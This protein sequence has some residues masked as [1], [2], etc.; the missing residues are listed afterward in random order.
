MKKS[1]STRDGR[2]VLRRLVLL[3]QRIRDTRGEPTSK[4]LLLD[5]LHAAG[6]EISFRTLDSDLAELRAFAQ[7][8]GSDLVY[9]PRQNAYRYSDHTHSFLAI[10]FTPYHLEALQWMEAIGQTVPT[11]VYTHFQGAVSRALEAFELQRLVNSADQWQSIFQVEAPVEAGREFVVPLAKAC[12]SHEKLE[13]GYKRYFSTEVRIH[14]VLPL[15]LRFWSG[16]WYLVA[17]LE[18]KEEP[19][20]F[21]CDRIESVQF[22]GLRIPKER[23]ND[24]NQLFYYT[25]GITFVSKDPPAAPVIFEVAEVQVPFLKARPLHHSQKITSRPGGVA[26]VQL[27]VHWNYELG[28]RLLGLGP[29]LCKPTAQDIHKKLIEQ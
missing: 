18:H 12:L 13:L 17:Q 24:S 3:D 21:G 19:T 20:V 4:K 16:Y 1:S 2:V 22:T 25:Y 5:Y 26:E 9:H 11:E 15:Q 8:A 28:M 7:D 10:P 29:A 6:Y 27:N 14:E 23:V